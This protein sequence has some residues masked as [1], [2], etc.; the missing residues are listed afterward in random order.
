M[1]GPFSPLTVRLA[2]FAAVS[3][4]GVNAA[5]ALL[6]Q[7]SA[8]HDTGLW[9]RGVQGVDSWRPMKQAYGAWRWPCRG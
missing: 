8:L 6:G 1:T 7:P 2:L 3:L 5:L 4:L 9:L